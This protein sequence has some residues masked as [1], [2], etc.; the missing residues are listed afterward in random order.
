M[1][2]ADGRRQLVAYD[3]QSVERDGSPEPYKL[4]SITGG[5]RL[6]IGTADTFLDPGQHTYQITYRTD[7]QIRFFADHDEFYW[8]VTGNGWAFPILEASA[9]ISLPEGVRPTGTIFFTGPQGATGKHARALVEGN[10]VFFA[11][12]RSLDAGEAL[13]VAVKVAKGVFQPPSA[14]QQTLWLLRDFL[15]D[16]IAYVGLAVVLAYYTRFWWLVGR[17]PPAGVVVPRWDAPEELS[18]ALVN[19]IDN[20]GFSGGGWTALSAAA[21]NLAV[22]GYLLIEDLDS[23]LTLTRT[24]KPLFAA[25]PPGKRHFSPPSPRR[26]GALSSIAPMAR[27]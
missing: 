12:T 4:E 24:N 25:L 7:R 19:Y 15:G 23:S 8:N 9:T 27:G 20:K 3:V 2:D 5:E 18:P 10:E 21:I 17:D 26:A 6:R 11:T 13:T 22:A 16:I 1:R 14:S